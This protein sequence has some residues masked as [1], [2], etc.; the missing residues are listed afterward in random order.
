MLMSHAQSGSHIWTW[1]TKLIK[2]QKVLSDKKKVKKA[3][4]QASVK[5]I[6]GKANKRIPQK[7]II[8][9]VRLGVFFFVCFFFIFNFIY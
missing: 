4:P 3:I 7:T 1:K 8:K 5:K 6:K 9:K 2:K